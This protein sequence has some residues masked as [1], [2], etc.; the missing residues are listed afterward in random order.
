VSSSGA[1]NHLASAH[2]RL[3]SLFDFHFQSGSARFLVYLHSQ[4]R[5]GSRSPPIIGAASKQQV[6]M[7]RKVITLELRD[8]F[9]DSAS[10]NDD[11]SSKL[12]PLDC[13]Y[14][15]MKRLMFVICAFSCAHRAAQ[16]IVSL[17]PYQ[18]ETSINVDAYRER[19]CRNISL[20]SISIKTTQIISSLITRSSCLCLFTSRQTVDKMKLLET[21]EHNKSER[22]GRAVCLHCKVNEKNPE[23]KTST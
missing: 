18:H 1:R 19:E 7:G 10:S 22:V 4:R 3:I 12:N 8:S 21:S 6:E 23:C 17:A 13:V 20:I 16:R 2:P 14:C 11:L 9:I 5:L 15:A